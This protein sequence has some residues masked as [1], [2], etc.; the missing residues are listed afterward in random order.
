MSGQIVTP[1]CRRGA[2]APLEMIKFRPAGRFH[3]FAAAK[4]A[5]HGV[6]AMRMSR[7][8]HPREKSLH[9]ADFFDKLTG[10]GFP[11]LFFYV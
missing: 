4:S 1:D 7:Q 10:R 11:A 6:F 2:E 3:R 8:K 9:F 5:G